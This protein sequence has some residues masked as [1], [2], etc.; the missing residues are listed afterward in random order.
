MQQGCGV[1]LPG[2]WGV[3]ALF[4]VG[5][6][7]ALAEHPPCTAKALGPSCLSS[8]GVYYDENCN[9]ENVNHA[10]LAVGYGTQKG[11]KHWIIKNR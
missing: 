7:T 5:G 6:G 10:V 4:H 8:P 2:Q 3:A 11:A 1:S 9:G